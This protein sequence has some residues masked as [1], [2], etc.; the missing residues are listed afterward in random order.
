MQ[1]LF[2]LE[3][4]SSVM[5]LLRIWLKAYNLLEANSAEEALRIFTDHGRHIS[6]LVADLT[7]PARSGIQVALLLRS[8]IPDVP[9]ILTSGDPVSGWGERDSAELESLGPTS[10]RILQKPFKAQGLVKAVYELIGA[11]QTAKVRTA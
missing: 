3:D 5:K 10:V 4:E 11:P 1:T 6:F 2:L 9:V 8:E 7:L